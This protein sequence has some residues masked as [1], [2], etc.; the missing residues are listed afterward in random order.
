MTI[1]R[2]YKIECKYYEVAHKV[3]H[4]YKTVRPNMACNSGL[5]FSISNAQQVKK[6]KTK[7]GN[8][9]IYF[10]T[11]YRTEMKLIAIT[12]DQCLLQFDAL[13][14]FQGCVYMGGLYLALIFFNVKPP[15][16]DNEFVKC[17]NCLDTNF[18]NISGF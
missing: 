2:L 15:K 8:T 12:M 17:T 6:K 18:H 9:P 13:K 5:I 4:Q 7:E 3:Y 1:N 14:F 11:H 16:F 10:N